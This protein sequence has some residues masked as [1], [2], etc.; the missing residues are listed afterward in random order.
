LEYLF[1]GLE[2][3]APYGGFENLRP[4]TIDVIEKF[5]SWHWTDNLVPLLMLVNDLYSQITEPK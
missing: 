4:E 1:I 5:N 3:G 2:S